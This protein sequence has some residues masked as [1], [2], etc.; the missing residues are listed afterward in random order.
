MRQEADLLQFPHLA[1]LSVKLHFY[2]YDSSLMMAVEQSVRESP[3]EVSII[4]K[5][6]DGGEK[7]KNL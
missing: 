3:S 5:G 4:Y 2:L 1:K 6:K 7:P